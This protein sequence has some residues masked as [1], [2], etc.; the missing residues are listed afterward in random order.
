MSHGA[1]NVV[2]HAVFGSHLSRRPGHVAPGGC[3]PAKHSIS[4]CCPPVP[5]TDSIA[6]PSGWLYSK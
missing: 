5:L 4:L 1:P 2:V 3:A 6:F